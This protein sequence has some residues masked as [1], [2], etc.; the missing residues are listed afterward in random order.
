MVILKRQNIPNFITCFRLI[1]TVPIGFFL[2][3]H[4]LSEAFYFFTFAAISDGLDG[5][6]ARHFHWTS[7]FGSFV[8]PLADKLLMLTSFTGLA[9]AQQVPL[10]LF[11]IVVFRDIWIMLG[12]AFFWACI[13]N[14]YFEPRSISKI[15]TVL[16]SALVGFLLLQ[17]AFHAIPFIILESFFYVVLISTLLSLLDY[18]IVGI[19]RASL[20]LKEKYYG[21]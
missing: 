2:F 20:V 14:L 3:N 16:Q 11:Y 6:L 19:W 17:G 8:D 10:W 1:L 4:R 18:T 15:N 13:S 9:Y 21:H 7:H 12:V 5:W